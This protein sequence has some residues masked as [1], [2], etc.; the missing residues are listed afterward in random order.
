MN[1]KKFITISLLAALLV[2][3]CDLF[4]P[5]S[6]D[7]AL[8]EW[9]FS[10]T[11]ISGKAATSIHLSVMSNGQM[12]DMR[13]DTSENGYLFAC[14]GTLSKNVFT[15]T[16][17]GW[18]SMLPGDTQIVTGESI[19]RYPLHERGKN[20]GLIFRLRPLERGFR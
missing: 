6:I 10:D 13:W 11:T 4:A 12:L 7:D 5:F 16:Y 9:D 2:A 19:Y 8:G 15:G 3:G 17:T 1:L 18:D 20:L 14:D